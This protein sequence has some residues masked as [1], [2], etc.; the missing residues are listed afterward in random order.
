MSLTDSLLALSSKIDRAT[1]AVNGASRG[2][3][4]V[5]TVLNSPVDVD[6]RGHISPDFR[7]GMNRTGLDDPRV[8][9]LA[10][11][12]ARRELLRVLASDP[13]VQI[14]TAGPDDPRSRSNFLGPDDPRRAR[15][16][17]DDP[18]LQILFLLRGITWA[19]LVSQKI[20]TQSHV[21]KFAAKLDT[22]P[23]PP[24]SPVVKAGGFFK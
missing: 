5:A 3:R 13:R 19:K 24:R 11:P 18:R 10:Q 23:A 21:G 20:P 6:F 4:H 2:M 9:A 16:G 14:F 15:A 12:E 8:Q 7:S 17:V 22:S 1:A